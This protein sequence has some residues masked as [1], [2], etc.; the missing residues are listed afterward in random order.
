[1]IFYPVGKF[2][3]EF[4]N[5]FGGG[6]KDGVPIFISRLDNV[7]KIIR[8]LITICIYLD[9]STNILCS[10][11]ILFIFLFKF[12]IFILD[13]P[14]EWYEWRTT[15]TTVAKSAGFVKILL[16]DIYNDTSVVINML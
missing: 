9:K 13:C 1:L 12:K 8:K 10:F 15:K 6:G 7:R 11:L 5:S 3:L 14:V 4:I 16:R 2:A